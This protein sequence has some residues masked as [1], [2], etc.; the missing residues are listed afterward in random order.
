MIVLL[1]AAVILTACVTDAKSQ[2]TNFEEC[3]AA[4]GDIMESYPRQCSVD[5]LSFTELIRNRSPFEIDCFDNGGTWIEDS[6]ECEGI[7][8]ETCE[9]LGGN[10][11]ECASACRNDPDAQI[12]T[13][14]CVVVCDFKPQDDV[15]PVIPEDCTSWFDGCNTCMV[16]D[17]ELGGCTRMACPAAALEEPKCLAFE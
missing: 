9:D 7:S 17:G 8:K 14:Q 1:F 13:L 5:D 3:V 15:E 10:F 2:P 4:G 6:L 11:D 16:V 12:C